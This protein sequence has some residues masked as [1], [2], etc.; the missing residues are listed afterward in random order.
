MP[1]TFCTMFPKRRCLGRTLMVDTPPDQ[2]K[3]YAVLESAYRHLLQVHPPQKYRSHG[4]IKNLRPISSEIEGRDDVKKNH[5]KQKGTEKSGKNRMKKTRKKTK[6][7]EKT[8][9]TRKKE[10]KI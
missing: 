8:R 3:C 5:Q 2:E 6:K 9:K 1:E 7:N 4:C 10:R